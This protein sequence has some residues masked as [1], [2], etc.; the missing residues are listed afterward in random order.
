MKILAITNR[1]PY[2]LNDGGNVATMQML[3]SLVNCGFEVKLLSL[4]TNK[5]FVDTATLPR[6]FKALGLETI[7]I[8]TDITINGA[9]TNLLSGKSYNA[10]RF[11]NPEF[12][13]LLIRTLKETRYDIV[14]FENIYS[15]TYIDTVKGNSDALC[16]L[17]PHNVEH[18]IWER[19]SLDEKLLKRFYIR[20]LAGRL[21]KFELETWPKFDAM[22]PISVMDEAT[23]RTYAPAAHY[24][25]LPTAI[26]THNET[27]GNE[28]HILNVFHLG[29]MNWIPNLQSM[30]WFMK[31][32]WPTVEKNTKAV[33]HMAGRS[34]PESFFNYAGERVFVYA[35]VEDAFEFMRDK[36]IMVVP[37][38]AG[39][40][41]RIKILEGMAAGKTIITTSLG[42]QG[43]DA[44]DK[45]Q[46]LIANNAS[47]FA[48]AVTWC[49]KNEKKSR[50]IGNRARQFI[51]EKYSVQSF[52]SKLKQFFNG[53][54]AKT[55]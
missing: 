21:K 43:I 10:I 24:L 22:I 39:S 40:G 35:D 8:N 52:E 50:E 14:H 18:E 29:S 45:E 11:F 44:F 17:R 4:N 6:F 5:H 27:V 2:P 48:E 54:I 41:V 49:I 47:A 28:G 42:V 36:Q 38:F 55:I 19:A 23:I 1:V 25:T 31:N 51:A 30:E 3:E 7:N 32:V 12:R 53:L 26:P 34:M 37:L 9:V 16:V 20:L 46:L 33:F 15:A 13:D